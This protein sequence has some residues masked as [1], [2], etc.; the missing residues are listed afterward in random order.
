MSF[1]WP[2]LAQPRQAQIGGTPSQD[3]A[4]SEIDAWLAKSVCARAQKG[5]ISAFAIARSRTGRGR[6]GAS[7]P[8]HSPAIDKAHAPTR[9]VP[10]RLL[11][12]PDL[13]LLLHHRPKAPKSLLVCVAVSSATSRSTLSSTSPLASCERSPLPSSLLGQLSE[14]DNNPRRSFLLR[15]PTSL[16]LFLHRLTSPPTT[17]QHVCSS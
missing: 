4:G 12:G 8:L 1:A 5:K 6:R 2:S 11:G 9:P 3:D 16:P 13:S 17:V 7:S 10:A 14:L 15:P